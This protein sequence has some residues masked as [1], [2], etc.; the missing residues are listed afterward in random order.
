MIWDYRYY[1]GLV[2]LA[3]IAFYVFF[4]RSPD[5]EYLVEEV[6]E[7]RE[8]GGGGGFKNF[9]YQPCDGVLIDI[10]REK[11]DDGQ[12]MMVFQWFLGLL[13][14]H[15]QYMPV[16]GQVIEVREIDGGHNSF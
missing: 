6:E 1:F 8:V 14:L 3:V 7:R 2:M 12:E 4:N 16:S 13:D 10:R 9:I 5:L 11:T 15:T